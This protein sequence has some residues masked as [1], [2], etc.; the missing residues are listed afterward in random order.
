MTSVAILSSSGASRAAARGGEQTH[1]VNYSPGSRTRSQQV[2]PAA[3]LGGSTMGGRH[4]CALQR[5]E[6][7]REKLNLLPLAAPL[8]TVKNGRGSSYF[9]W[10]MSVQTGASSP[11]PQQ[12]TLI[13]DCYNQEQL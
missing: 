5:P 4:T 1:G 2:G 3:H 7:T 10:M 13:R 8:I 12:N 11:G 6:Q 9:V